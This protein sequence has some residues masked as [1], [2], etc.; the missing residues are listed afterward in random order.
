MRAPREVLANT[1]EEATAALP[2][3]ELAYTSSNH[4]MAATLQV[5]F[6]SLPTAHL[7][8]PLE[9]TAALELTGLKYPADTTAGIPTAAT[10]EE[11]PCTVAPRLVSV[12]GL[13]TTTMAASSNTTTTTINNNNS[14][15]VIVPLVFLQ[16]NIIRPIPPLPAV[17][18]SRP[19]EKRIF[20]KILFP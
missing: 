7:T 6:N 4:L 8:V 13:L 20:F 5:S 17:Y 2:E 9:A 15:G 19:I 16:R 12:P 1:A 11:A 10:T 3:V 18:L 14:L